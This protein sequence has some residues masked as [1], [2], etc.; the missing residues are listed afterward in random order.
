MKKYFPLALITFFT[1]MIAISCDIC[2]CGVGTNYV[3]ILPDFRKHIF[4]FRYRFNTMFTHVGS[5][6]NFTYLTTKETYTT[7][8]AWGGWNIGKKF[9]VMLSIPYNYNERI[10]LGTINKKNGIGDITLSGYYQLINDK[11]SVGNNKLL[12][13]N[14]WIGAGLKLATGKYNT[15][16]KNS[17]NN[18]SNLFQLGTGSNDFNIA[19][20]YDLRIQDMGINLTSAY[21][22]TTTNKY[23]Y[24]YGG[25]F[26][27]N[28]QAYYKFRIKNKWTAAPNTGV[29]YEKSNRD[30]DNGFNVIASGGGLLLGTIGVEAVFKKIA[31]GANLQT[32]FSQNLANSIAKANNRVMIHIALT[33]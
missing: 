14:L 31:F 20:M 28:A 9:R 11:K 8:E 4:G 27:I 3:G 29:Q 10:N 16:D 19:A 22:I 30:L 32:P 7:I 24:K 21:K 2:G 5:D 26:N 12:L 23:D 18:N 25:K 6:G 13:Q 1:P 33:Y 15:I 17:T